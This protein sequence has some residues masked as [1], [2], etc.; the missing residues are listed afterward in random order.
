MKQYSFE[1]SVLIN[2]G[3]EEL[4]EF[5]TDVNNLSKVSPNFIRTEILELSDNPL[6]LN[7]K[8]VLK[9]KLILFSMYWHIRISELQKPN[10]VVDLQEKGIFK[11]W[12]H[13]HEFVDTPDGVIMTDKVQFYP[14]LGLFALPFV[15]LQLMHMFSYRHKKTKEIFEKGN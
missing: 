11:Y 8:I 2:C 13:R 3:I 14:P 6:E 9:V 7:S 10:L 15:K 12:A 4:F 1:K 5:H